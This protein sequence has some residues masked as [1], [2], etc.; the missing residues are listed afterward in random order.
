MG[1]DF[2]QRG[3]TLEMDAAPVPQAQQPKQLQANRSSRLADIVG[4]R[5]VQREPVPA[6]RGEPP[7]DADQ[8][9]AGAQP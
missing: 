7:F 5:T 3:T 1:F 9:D 8:A 4:S 2:N 6:E